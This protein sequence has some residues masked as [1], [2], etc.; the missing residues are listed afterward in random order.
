MQYRSR[1]DV[2][3]H[4]RSGI[5]TRERCE[6]ELETYAA[7]TFSAVGDELVLL[8]EQ[9]HTA[10][11][12]GEVGLVWLSSSPKTAEVGYVFNPMF[13]GQGFATEAV[14]GVVALAFDTYG[15]DLV[16][17]TTDEANLASRALCG[18]LGMQ[19]SATTVSTDGRNVPECT[20]VLDRE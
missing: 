18:R 1:P 4:L 15:F 5:W 17:A 8:A 9:R 13:G 20:Y 14:R 7:A 11:V 12:I 6:Q 2:G 16:V 3:R 10:G 19:L